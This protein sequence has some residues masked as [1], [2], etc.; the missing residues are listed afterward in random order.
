VNDG[1][2]RE[3]TGL[4]GAYLGD[5]SV[6]LRQGAGWLSLGL[7]QQQHGCVTQYVTCFDWPTMTYDGVLCVVAIA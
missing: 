2:W 7:Q 6:H 1:E 5:D 3:F 4:T